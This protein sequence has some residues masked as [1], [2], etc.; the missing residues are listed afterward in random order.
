MKHLRKFESYFTKDI[1]VLPP[2]PIDIDDNNGGDDGGDSQEFRYDFKFTG[3][4]YNIKTT[5]YSL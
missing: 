2:P 5:G 3:L 4:R 1:D